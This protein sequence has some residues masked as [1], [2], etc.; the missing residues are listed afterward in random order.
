[1]I[2]NSAFDN[3]GMTSFAL[4]STA[5]YSGSVSTTALTCSSV[6]IDCSSSV[7]TC[8]V[9]GQFCDTTNVVGS[10]VNTCQLAQVGY[11]ATGE[12]GTQIECGTGSTTTDVGFHRCYCAMG[13][14]GTS[15]S[16][17]TSGCSLCD[18]ETPYTEAGN[19]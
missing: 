14:E 15:S 5:T 13:Y 7:S 10:G 18:A 12:D 6:G 11:Y 1:M 17:G 2:D 4:P 8:N 16:D 9:P 3:S 19:G